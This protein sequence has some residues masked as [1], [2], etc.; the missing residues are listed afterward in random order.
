MLHVITE[1]LPCGAGTVCD[2]N[3][4]HQASDDT[5]LLC[6][7]TSG[8]VLIAGTMLIAV[9]LAPVLLKIAEA[10]KHAGALQGPIMSMVNFFQSADLFKHLN[11]HWPPK[12][13]EFIQTFAQYFNFQ[14]PNLPFV[15]HPEC[16]FS[17]VGAACIFI[18]HTSGGTLYLFAYPT[19]PRLL[20]VC[21]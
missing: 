11:L 20:N 5:C 10:V 15:V 19:S 3:Y 7:Q 13:K 21:C 4:Y 9:I 1:P 17:L 18:A 14:L 2:G 8:K 12:F 16:A 6:P